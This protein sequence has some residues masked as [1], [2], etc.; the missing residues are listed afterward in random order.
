MNEFASW[1]QWLIS[2]FQFFEAKLNLYFSVRKMLVNKWKTPKM[3]VFSNHHKKYK[4]KD[5]IW[6]LF[7]IFEILDWIWFGRNFTWTWTSQKGR[8]KDTQSTQSKGGGGSQ[9]GRKRK[10][11]IFARQKTKIFDFLKRKSKFNTWVEAEINDISSPF[12]LVPL[13]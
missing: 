1:L 11:P 7:I 13:R 3:T 8:S 10:R 6:V 12:P 2:R 4:K 9:F 5:D